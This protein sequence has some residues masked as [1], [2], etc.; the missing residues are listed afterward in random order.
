MYSTVYC[1][2]KIQSLV[3]FTVQFSV[4]QTVQFLVLCAVQCTGCTPDAA[5]AVLPRRVHSYN[6]IFLLQQHHL[7][8]A[9]AVHPWW[10]HRY[11]SASLLK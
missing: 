10:V 8:D 3:L 9:A 7:P 4:A 11:S 5:A 2:V 1:F 6:S